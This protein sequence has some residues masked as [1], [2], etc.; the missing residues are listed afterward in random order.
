M[1]EKLNIGI[2]GSRGIP[3]R[4]GGFEAFAHQISVR[5]AARGHRITVYTTHNHPF[6]ESRYGEV[7][8][9]HCYNPEQYLGAAGQLVY[10]GLCNI[11]SRS[12][13]YDVVLHLGYTSDA[14]WHFLWPRSSRHAVNMDGMEWQRAK[15]SNSAKKFLQRS[16][17]W[18]AR[19]ADHLIADSP[20]IESYLTRHYSTPVSFIPY[21]T[22]I[23]AYFDQRIPGV[24]GLS[25][26]SYELM[27]ARMEPENHIEMAID[28]HLKTGIQHPLVIIG[29]E[30]SYRDKLVAKYKG[31]P[32]ILL[33]KAVYEPET[34][35][36]L[37]HFSRYYIHG[38]SAGGTNPSLLEAMACGCRILAHNN[39]YNKAVTADHAGYFTD[40]NNLAEL[41]SR[42]TE[43]NFWAE[44]GE[45]NVSRIKTI[46]HPDRIADQYEKLFYDLAGPG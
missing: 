40:A 29:N 20:V 6:R 24:Y 3:N 14:L 17:K 10:D 36:S 7:R 9:I 43:G 18:A 1:P 32:G 30:N 39:A 23:P 11:H 15:Y 26:G 34:T 31:N 21:G 33:L 42:P 28:A 2:I 27:I 41:L 44:W 4:Y 8:L 46:Y 25:P 45:A 35:A 13:S 16:E 22:E 12:E 5:L 19:K 38:H 37:R